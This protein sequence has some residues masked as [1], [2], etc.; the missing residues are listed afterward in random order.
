MLLQLWCENNFFFFLPTLHSLAFCVSCSKGYSVKFCYNFGACGKIL[1]K[2]N[3][4]FIGLL[5]Q[6]ILSLQFRKIKGKSIFPLRETQINSNFVA[7]VRDCRR[8]S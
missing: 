1:I 5:T 6:N 4:M 2:F 3:G 8:V 7:C